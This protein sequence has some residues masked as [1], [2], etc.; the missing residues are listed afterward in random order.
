[1]TVFKHV[2]RQKMNRHL[3]DTTVLVELLRGNIL[4]KKFLESSPEISKIT[5][6]E[7]IQG[8]KNK[9][10]LR[11]VEKACDPLHQ[12]KIN[13]EISSLAIDLLRKYNLSHGLLFLDALIAATCIIRK[14]ILVTQNLRDFRFIT[15]LEVI[16]QKEAFVTS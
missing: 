7:L 5:L 8:C 1:M 15:G 4:A 6:V 9:E 2:L 14:N 11:L 13:S 3:V 16:S 10:E 12:I